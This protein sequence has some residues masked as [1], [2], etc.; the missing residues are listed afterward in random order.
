MR[1]LVTGASGAVGQPL[2]VELRGRG[3]VVRGFDRAQEGG[4]DA[5]DEF[6]TGD[7]ADAAL[8]R[9][10]VDGVDAIVHLAAIPDEAP[11]ADLVTPNFLGL[12]H[13]LDAARHYHVR[14]VILASTV[15]AVAGAG[16][17]KRSTSLRVPTNHYALTK[18]FAEDMG[19]MYAR[20]FGLQ[21]VA[22]RIGWMVR[23]PRE[24][25]LIQ[26]LNLLEWYVSRRDVAEFLH[27]ALHAPFQGFAAAYVI[28]RGG[29][30]HFDF[31]PGLR[32]FGFEPRDSFPEGLPFPVPQPG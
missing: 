10:A 6:V 21:V 26:E 20:R 13:V 23:S 9:S 14:R 24:A 1:V 11:F 3:D 30:D 32:L 8:V 29:R 28:G 16:A 19:E 5:C 12:F 2:C 17:G 15:Q 18:L 4:S 25:A 22:A 31:E 7:L 27:A